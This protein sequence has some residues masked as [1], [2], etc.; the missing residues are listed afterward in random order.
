MTTLGECCRCSR[1]PVTRFRFNVVVEDRA[2]QKAYTQ[3]LCTP[4]AGG[5]ITRLRGQSVER[6]PQ[7]ELDDLRQV[8]KTDTDEQQA[9]LV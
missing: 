3:L 2:S 1:A 4:C 8:L 9:Q 5:L 6:T 7:R